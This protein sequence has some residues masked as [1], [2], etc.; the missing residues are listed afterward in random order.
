MMKVVLYLKNLSEQL[1]ATSE[2]HT[3]S[4]TGVWNKIKK[5][6]TNSQS[7]LV[8]TNKIAIK[9]NKILKAALERAE[10]TI[11]NQQATISRHT[12]TLKEHTQTVQHLETII[13]KQDNAMH[14][15]ISTV[16]D[17]ESRID[18]LKEDLVPEY[19]KTVHEQCHKYVTHESTKQVTIF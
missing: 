11:K 17:N 9:N 8:N 6:M 13:T 2:Q 19:V 16:E 7:Q 12:T 4:N 3:Q 18:V 15:L 10:G 5:D 1:H 14:T